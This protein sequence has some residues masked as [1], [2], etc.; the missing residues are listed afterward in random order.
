MTTTEIA[1]TAILVGGVSLC[2]AIYKV[3]TW[4]YQRPR[5]RRK[6]TTHGDS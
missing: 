1:V 2:I 3:A 5:Y 4:A 6:G